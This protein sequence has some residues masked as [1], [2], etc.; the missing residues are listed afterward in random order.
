MLSLR[1]NRLSQPGWGQ[2]KG[3]SPEWIRE[4][5]SRCSRRSKDRAQVGHWKGLS[6]QEEDGEGD[7]EEDEC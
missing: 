7:L 2:E 5:R 6:R 3:R 1:E 4:W